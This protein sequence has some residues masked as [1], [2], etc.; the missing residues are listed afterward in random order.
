[1]DWR[2]EGVLLAA[3]RHGES[4]A[5]IEVFTEGHGRHAGIVRGGAS[6][7]IAPIL[8]PGAQL[9]VSWRARLEEHLGAFS[10]EPVKSRAHLMSAR[11]T[12]AALNAATAILSFAL[13]EREPHPSLYAKTIALLD[14]IG[15]GEFWPVAYLRWEMAV[16]EDLGFGLDLSACAA[17][18]ATDDLA[19]VSP[20]T[21]RAVSKSGAGDWA[22][23]L[24]PLSPALLG[25]GNGSRAEV[26]L[27][28]RATGHFLETGLAASLGDRPLPAARGR[29]AS[30]LERAG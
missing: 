20:K 10:V 17:T 15:E 24:L 30:M 29:F 1:M 8:Q 25:K 28:L 23:R 14:M 6:R 16:L 18:G 4:A 2:E 7:K 26:S 19:F 13:P 5:I 11:D 21:G 9:D 12:L 3:R 27:G 22:D